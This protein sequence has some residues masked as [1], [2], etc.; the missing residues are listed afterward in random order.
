MLWHAIAPVRRY[1]KASHDVVRHPRLCSD[2]KI[3]LLYVQ[4]LPDD[5]THL[6][7][8]EHGLKL[9]IKGRA[10][11]RAKEQLVV[12]G[13][14]HERRAAGERG[15]WATHQLVSN[16][17]LTDADALAVWRGA[18]VGAG[19]SPSV[20]FPTV[21]EPSPRSVGHQLP[22]DEELGKNSS[23]PP[24]EAPS[25]GE[26]GGEGGAVA[27]EVVELSAQEAEA[28]RV[29]LSL[30][31]SDR[32]LRLG[33]L[34][35]RRLVGLA[36]EWLRRGVSAGELR[37]VL[38]SGLPRDGVRSAVGFLGHRLVQKMPEAPEGEK[39]PV[40]AEARA[41][42]APPSDLPAAPP[43]PPYVPPLVTCQGP[44]N[45]H[46][47]RAYSEETECPD[48]QQAAAYARWAERRAADL[49]IDLAEDAAKAV[50]A[51]RDP[52]GW[53]S[54]LAAAAAAAG[55]GDEQ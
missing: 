30:R 28:E 24:T 9:G 43:A 36:V 49:G 11:Q 10:F 41:E 3:L 51:G 26:A 23:R 31:N 6:A 45:E 38:S 55:G 5:E 29:L 53:R 13:F 39:P 15:L 25:Q 47:F 20:Q 46:V 48:C 44:G 32:Q 16:V 54:R 42:E 7:L 37:R 2:A 34:E 19:D 12:N 27:G 8:S 1:T 33:V 22:V 17:P 52:D 40:G 4:G 14:V 50:E 18:G 21:G 35:A